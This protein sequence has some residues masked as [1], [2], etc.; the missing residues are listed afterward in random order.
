MRKRIIA[1]QAA[2]WLLGGATLAIS[3]QAKAQ[4][5]PPAC[6]TLTNVVY[7]SGSSAFKPVLQA[8]ANVLGSS[9][10]IVNSKPGS[11]EG[12]DFVMK[13]TKD[14][15][16]PL[17]VF[18]PGNNTNSSCLPA[19]GGTAVDIGFSDVYPS[20]C[21]ASFDSTLPAIGN[22]KADF[23]GPVQAMTFAVP[24][25]SSENSISAEAAY[26]V[27]G[28][29]AATAS[30]TIMPWNAP[31]NIYVRFWDS[32]TLEMLATAIGLPG[33]KWVAS[34][35][36]DPTPP[37]A[38]QTTF[39]ST[40]DMQGALSKAEM[41]ATTQSTAIGI[42]ST[43]GLVAGV[44]KGL[45]FQGTGQTCSYYPDS[46]ATKADKINVRQGRYQVWGPEHMVVNVDAMGNPVGQNNNTVA[47]QTL[48]TALSATSK[49][50]PNMSDGGVSEAGVTTLGEAE[51][52][53]IIK[54]ISAPSAGFIPQCAMQV[55]R[56]AEIGPE[57]S[58]MPPAACSC[59]FETA[60]GTPLSGH[61]CTMCTSNADCANT[62]GAPVC[63]FNYCEVQ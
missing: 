57:A 37:A 45:A 26:M 47:V 25:D 29:G 55:S 39:A 11:C 8:V 33:G 60:T 50:L 3:G 44:T 17:I 46:A 20:T 16:S 58:Y 6:S 56:T 4:A 22:G 59:A 42:L 7:T 13:G 53:Q 41:S 27:F 21:T 51:V 23:L 15:T 19:T 43:S 5:T 32:G 1:A 12:L 62:P 61:T 63:R 24:T 2:A 52:G 54:A 49:A 40:G 30:K 18:V 14:T 34:T 31:G 9:V 10:T 36:A 48:I 35:A 28:Y 38:G